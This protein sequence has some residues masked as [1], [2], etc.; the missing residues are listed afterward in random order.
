MSSL[1][2]LNCTVC[3]ELVVCALHNFCMHWCDLC[4]DPSSHHMQDY[5]DTAKL[6]HRNNIHM[7]NL[8]GY[9]IE[10]AGWSTDLPKLDYVVSGWVWSCM[11]L[12]VFHF[13][14]ESTLLLLFV[15]IPCLHAC[16]TVRGEK[17][18]P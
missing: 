6:L 5:P 2:K 4:V 17:I 14:A 7:E 18:E 3:I 11:L 8:Y 16:M 9:A 12:C 13:F 15:L 1:W 10:A